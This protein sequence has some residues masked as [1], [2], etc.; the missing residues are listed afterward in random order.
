MA[1]DMQVC[2]A[3]VLGPAFAIDKSPGLVCFSLKFSSA[4]FSPYID[5]PP[6]PWMAKKVSL[7]LQWQDDASSA[8]THVA[9]GEVT[10]LEHEF[11]DDTMELGAG[12]TK[13][14]LAGAESTEILS[15]LGDDVVVKVEVDATSL[16][17]DDVSRGSG[18]G[19]SCGIEGIAFNGKRW[20]RIFPHL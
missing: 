18:I 2:E 6:V 5:L 20:G 1:W 9:A 15:G 17:C 13:A 16:F 11:R 19:E 12:V 8:E 4:N 10:A 14:L 7:S 3:H